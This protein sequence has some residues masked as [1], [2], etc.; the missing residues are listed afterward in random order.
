MKLRA[1]IA[2]FLI[3]AN[4]AFAVGVVIAVIWRDDRIRAKRAARLR[5]MSGIVRPLE[6]RRSPSI[7]ARRR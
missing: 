2:H 1:I 6:R 7:E 5:S 3:A 4:V